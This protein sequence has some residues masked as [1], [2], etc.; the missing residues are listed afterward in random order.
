MKKIAILGGLAAVSLAFSPLHTSGPYLD[1]QGRAWD[2]LPALADYASAAEF[3]ALFA[4]EVFTTRDGNAFQ[5]DRPWTLA[6]ELTNQALGQIHQGAGASR[7]PGGGIRAIVNLT[8]PVDEEYRAAYNNN[9]PTIQSH[10]VG[11]VNSA[12]STMKANW[13]I[14]LV[15]KKGYAWDSNDAG[16]IVQLLD[17]AYSEGGGLNG[18][19]MMI[20]YSNDPTPGGA[21]GVAYLGLPRALVKKYQS[22]EANITEHEV[23]HTYTL[24]HC[25][26]GNCTMQ[27][28]LDIGAFHGFHNY[29]ESCSGQNHYTL[30]NNQ[31]NR[32]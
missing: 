19:D 12:D 16:D 20:A 9:V 7:V 11:V 15:P 13:G 10:V 30:M 28:V 17:E 1:S 18:Q 27:A 23:G 29:S 14:D 2:V 6:E 4:R 32:Y 8:H 22:Y 21:I 5:L 25:C 3:D 26:D 31:R 24:N